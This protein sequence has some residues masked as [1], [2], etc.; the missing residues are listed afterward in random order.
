MTLNPNIY[1]QL[2]KSLC[3]L[4]LI[5]SATNAKAQRIAHFNI[6]DNICIGDTVRVTFGFDMSH[7]IMYQYPEIT[8]GIVE[9]VFLPDGIPCGNMR[10]AYTST[11]NF[12]DFAE[13]SIITTFEAIRYLRLNI[14]HSYIADI[15]ISLT[16]PNGQTSTI[17]RFGGSPTAVCYS[18]IPDT[19]NTWLYGTNAYGYV[20]FG[21]PN[22]HDNE[23][24]NTSN[25]PSGTGWNYCWSNNTISDYNYASGDGIIYRLGHSHNGRIDSSDVASHSKFYHPDVHFNSLIGCPLNGN[26]TVKVIDGFLG[27]NGYLFSW[28]LALDGNLVESIE[29]PADSFVVLG[30]GAIRADDTSFFLTL[31]DNITHDST[32]RYI[33]KIYNNCGNV[34]DTSKYIT[35][36]AVQNVNINR[37]VIENNLPYT[38]ND[39]EFHDSISNYIFPRTDRFG[40][41]SIVHFNLNVW[42]NCHTYSDTIVCANELPTYWHDTLFNH[43][44]SI[45]LNLLTINGADSIVTARLTVYGSDTIDVQAHICNGV[46]YT[47]INGI[48]YYDNTQTPIFNIQDNANCDSIFRLNLFYSDDD[49]T[50]VI[51]AHPNPVSATNYNV[52]LTDITDSKSRIWTIGNMNDTARIC[53]FE[54]PLYEDSIIATLFAINKYGCNDSTSVIIRNGSH[55]LWAPNAFTPDE[56]INKKFFISTNHVRSGIVYIYSRTGN[57]ITSFDLVTGFWDGNANGKPCPQGSYVWKATYTT[58]NAPKIQLGDIGNFIL[59]R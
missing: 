32:V 20:D 59:I 46:P 31:P 56:Q 27:D 33:F 57:L 5:F 15:F 9:T 55:F 28:E 13:G 39:I 58:D 10:C 36:R 1:K 40:C 24:C 3:I 45:I 16:C 43:S 37:N 12:T 6:P 19:A 54:F 11:I 47:W 7:D 49:Y 4:L 14:E 25:N 2:S 38:Y 35:F 48:T 51:N 30:P 18:E 44:D 21:E 52:T 34:T 50:A 17:M 26:W 22:I 41:D 29:C 42:R 8:R 53:S 23:G